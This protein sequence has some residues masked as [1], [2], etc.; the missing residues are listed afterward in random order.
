MHK[1][2][3]GIVNW[4]FLKNLEMTKNNR[5]FLSVYVDEMFSTPA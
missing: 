4:T 2:W 3:L 1:N 5:F